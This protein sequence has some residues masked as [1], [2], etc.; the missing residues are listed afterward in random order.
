MPPVVTA[1]PRDR[2]RV[3]RSARPRL[4]VSSTEASVNFNGLIMFDMRNGKS[5]H[6]IGEKYG[7]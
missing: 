5:K 4:E 6:T 2:K 7:N 3:T 1:A